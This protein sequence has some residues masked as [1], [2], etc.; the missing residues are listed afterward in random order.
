VFAS[1]DGDGLHKGI[2]SL[3]H[4]FALAFDEEQYCYISNQDTNVITRLEFDDEKARTASAAPV[5]PGLSDQKTL[6]EGTFV[7]CSSAQL[8]GL[9][10]TT[11]VPPPQGLDVFIDSKLGKVHFSV[12][13][14]AVADG[15]LYVCDEPAGLIKVYD[16]DGRLKHSSNQVLRP[17]HL[18][19]HESQLFMSGGD[20]VMVAQLG[21]SPM[22]F[23]AAEGV[24]GKNVSG[25]SFARHGG[26]F[27]VANRNADCV[28]RYDVRHDGKFVNKKRLIENMSDHPEFLLHV[29]D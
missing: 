12:R 4:P 18:L 19:T 17:V 14:I 21:K 22:C 23:T 7:G 9:M 3:Y 2:N 6:F 16:T 1:R 8:P 29:K 25:M 27:F 24:E 5:P 13:G 10:P 26:L 15:L 20:E 28:C 11:P